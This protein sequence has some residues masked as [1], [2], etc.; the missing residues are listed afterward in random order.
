MD[1]SIYPESLQFLHPPKSIKQLFFQCI[2]RY[3]LKCYSSPPNIPFM[4][5]GTCFNT[6]LSHRKF[7]VLYCVGLQKQHSHKVRQNTTWTL[8]RFISKCKS[9]KIQKEPNRQKMIRQ[10]C[11]RRKSPCSGQETLTLV[12]PLPSTNCIWAILFVAP[13]FNSLTS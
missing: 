2:C 6:K 10:D 12:S 1:Y 9:D 8:P 3:L 7:L 13:N 5:K 11:G 4:I